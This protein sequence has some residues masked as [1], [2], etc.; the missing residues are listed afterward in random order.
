MEK[1]ES[2]VNKIETNEDDEIKESTDLTKSLERN[3]HLQKSEMISYN[4]SL[5][6]LKHAK[7]L[8]E[9][10]DTNKEKDIRIKLN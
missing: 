9:L 4:A 7:S 1:H 3:E 5:E 2:L 10:Y 6:I 8:S